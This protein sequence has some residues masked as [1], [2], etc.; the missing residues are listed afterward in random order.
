M[1]TRERIAPTKDL[2]AYPSIA[3]RFWSHVQRLG[4]RDC[5]PWKRGV[6]HYGYGQFGIN[7]VSHGAHRIAWSVTKGAIPEG[8]EVCHTCDNPI[9]VN[10]AHLFLGTHADNMK[11]M[12]V[13][14]RMTAGQHE[15]AKTHC[16]HGHA[17]TPENTYMATNPNGNPRRLC[18]AC[19]KRYRKNRR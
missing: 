1:A 11:D 18:I 10:P 7:H 13:K 15:A 12:R 6:N 19:R 5:W 14:G 2:R 9:C 17:Y 4:E 8:M 16:P 3:R